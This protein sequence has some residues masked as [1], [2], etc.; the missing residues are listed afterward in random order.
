MTREPDFKRVEKRAAIVFWRRAIQCEVAMKDALARGHWE[1]AGINAVHCAISAN[2]AALAAIPAI[3]VTSKDHRYAV[4][5]LS[6]RLKGEDVQAAAKRLAIIIS[7]KGR[8][9]YEQKRLSE[10]EAR[11]LVLDAER[12]L[13]WVGGKIPEEFK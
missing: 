1:A 6:S 2:D 9:E 13:D 8:V 7:R 5:L 3:K 4:R 10:K 12:F 11:S